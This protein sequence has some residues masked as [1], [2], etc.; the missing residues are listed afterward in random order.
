[1][2]DVMINCSINRAKALI[3]QG[4]LLIDLRSPVDFRNGS[5]PGAKNVIL[6][7]LQGELKSVNRTTPIIVFA[8]DD[9]SDDIDFAV[10]FLTQDGFTNVRSIGSIANW[11]NDQPTKNS[12]S[13]HNNRNKYRPRPTRRTDRAPI[14]VTVKKRKVS[15]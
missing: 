5:L 8:R 4:A 3:E 11:Y 9:D 1:M 15:Q 10:R 13:R 7:N 14:A 6:R 2:E 12:D